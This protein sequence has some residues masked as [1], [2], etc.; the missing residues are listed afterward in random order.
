MTAKAP[1]LCTVTHLC[2]SRLFR[3]F[4]MYHNRHV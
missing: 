1:N 2:S 4:G 3:Q